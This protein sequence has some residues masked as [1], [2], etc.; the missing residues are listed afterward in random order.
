MKKRVYVSFKVPR[1]L[2]RE[3]DRLVKKGW[4]RSRSELIRF[5]LIFFLIELKKRE[6]EWV[7]AM[8]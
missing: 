3:M 1:E 8:H 6:R 5:A 7:L 4:F 2:L